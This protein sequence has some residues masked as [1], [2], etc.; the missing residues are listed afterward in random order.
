MR[1]RHAPTLTAVLLLSSSPLYLLAVASV[2]RLDLRFAGMAVFAI[3]DRGRS[4]G[5]GEVGGE[6]ALL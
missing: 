6:V 1:H 2:A 3:I 4:G 5:G